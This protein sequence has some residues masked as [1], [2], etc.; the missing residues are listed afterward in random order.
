MPRTTSTE[1]LQRHRDLNRLWLKFPETFIVLSLTDQWRVHDYYQTQSTINGN[2]L[3][4][5]RDRL[6]RQQPSLPQTAGKAYRQL[7][8]CFQI[9]SHYGQGDPL[10]FFR[11]VM[12]LT[13]SEQAS[14]KQRT[15][16]SIHPLVRPAPD[17]EL[18][19]RAYIRI[20]E[21]QLRAVDDD[22]DLTA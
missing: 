14:L 13:K 1:H 19:T 8:R 12:A 9:A 21:E 2:Q 5:E 20:A 7:N 18:L 16:I 10:Q 17:V 22:L 3:L 15:G 6:S 4:D 11:A